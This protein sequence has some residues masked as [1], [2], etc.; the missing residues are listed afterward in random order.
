MSCWHLK[1]NKNS[2]DTCP[3]IELMVHSWWILHASQR[4]MI[5]FERQLWDTSIYLW[6]IIKLVILSTIDK[7][8]VVEI[9]RFPKQRCDNSYVPCPMA[10]QPR[11]RDRFFDDL[12]ARFFLPTTG[13]LIAIQTFLP[14]SGETLKTPKRKFVRIN[15]LAKLVEEERPRLLTTH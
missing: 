13:N 7:G 2:I 12:Q 14:L 4:L 9:Y 3:E 8:N 15:M 5:P 6:D 10:K 1:R 11:D